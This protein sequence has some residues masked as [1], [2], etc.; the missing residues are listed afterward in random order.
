MFSVTSVVNNSLHH[1]VVLIA[2]LAGVLA[3]S[4]TAAGADDVPPPS[5]PP[6]S[7]SASA[8]EAATARLNVSAASITELPASPEGFA[9]YRVNSSYQAG[10]T[11]L[12][13]L[14]PAGFDRG[15]RYRL[16]FVLPVEPGLEHRFGDGLPEVRRLDLHNKHQLICVAPT[17]SALPWYADHPTDPALRQETYFVDVVTPAVY[18]LYPIE[19][20]P[21]HCLLLGFSKSGYGAWSLLLRHPDLYGRAAAWDAPVDMDQPNRYGMQGVYGAQENFER[22]RLKTLLERRADLLK[23]DANR[24]RAPRLALFGY[25]NFRDQ[26]IAIHERLVALNIP[27]EYRDGP[28]RE[29]VW[30][31]GWIAEAVEWLVSPSR[32]K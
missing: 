27:H 17:F 25:G 24:N 6:A 8:L 21:E 26:H 15:K 19:P 31:S 32:R 10:D 1:S 30:E 2:C 23:E 11:E 20:S 12:R 5:A 7:N 13:V 3:W 9:R 16:L 29:H 28:K 22:Y 4:A 18:Q 14:T